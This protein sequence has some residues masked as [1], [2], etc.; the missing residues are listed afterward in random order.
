MSR[1]YTVTTSY[2]KV[3]IL[4]CSEERKGSNILADDLDSSIPAIAKHSGLSPLFEARRLVE[5]LALAANQKIEASTKTRKKILLPE[6]LLFET[7]SDKIY[8]KVLCGKDDFL[9]ITF[10]TGDIEDN[11]SNISAVFQI[12][13][14]NSL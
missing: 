5:I 14:K 4:Y 13:I 11:L 12:I 2:V 8:F 9:K 1:T 6:Q 3:T 10:L 7:R